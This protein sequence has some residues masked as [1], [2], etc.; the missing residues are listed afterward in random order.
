MKQLSHNGILIPK[1]EPKGFHILF[2]G[3]RINLTPEQEE[4]AVAWVRKLG[5]EYA[6]DKVFIKN[7]FNDFSKALEIKKASPEDFDFKEIK[8]FV[9]KERETK[10]NIPK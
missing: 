10:L 1:Y 5:T 6:Q 4:M 8:N 2:K 9:E 7:F 3:K